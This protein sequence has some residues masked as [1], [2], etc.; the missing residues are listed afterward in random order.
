MDQKRFESLKQKYQSAL[1]MIQQQGVQLQHLHEDNGKLIIQGKAPSEQAKNKVWDQ[2]KLV[3]PSYSDLSAD[4]SVDQSLAA[5]QPKTA[6][7]GASSG[8]GQSR[9]YTV[10]PGDSLSKIS[11]QFYGSSSQYMKIFEANRDKL[12]D[13]NKIQPGMELKIPA[14]A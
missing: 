4:I 11:E 12:N 1:N 10:K 13:P 7:A 14:N 6:A 9:T 8:D 5:N 3:D 2:I